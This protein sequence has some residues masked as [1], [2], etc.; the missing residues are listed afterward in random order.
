MFRKMYIDIFNYAGELENDLNSRKREIDRVNT[1]NGY[2]YK[3]HKI[4]ED[5]IKR[6]IEENRLL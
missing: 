4:K 6:L 1:L 5:M 2:L 3:A